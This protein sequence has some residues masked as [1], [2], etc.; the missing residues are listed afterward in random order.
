M[1]GPGVPWINWSGRQGDYNV[2][3]ID[4]LGPSLEDLF[5]MC[6]RHFSL[7]TI[8]MLADQLVSGLLPFILAGHGGLCGNAA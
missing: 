4:L 5:R 7:K 2:M 1:G 8:L 6:N 3:V